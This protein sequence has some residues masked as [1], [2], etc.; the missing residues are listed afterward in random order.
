MKKVDLEVANG[1][2]AVCGTYQNFQI[3]SDKIL[4]QEMG[5][6]SFFTEIMTFSNLIFLSVAILK[7]KSDQKALY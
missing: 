1:A 3:F 2:N 5:I 6:F 7:S 4:D